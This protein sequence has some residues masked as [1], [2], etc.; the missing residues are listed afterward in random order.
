MR[1]LLDEFEKTHPGIKVVYKMQSPQEYRER[2]QSALNNNN[3]PDVFRIHN[4]WLPMF[5]GALSPV[6]S[7]V[8]STVDY[9]KTFYPVTKTDFSSQGIYYAVP[10][11]TDGIA[12]YVNDDLLEQNN[13]SAPENWDQLKE[14]AITLAK[15]DS[16]TGSCEYG[17]KLT[18]AGVAIGSTKNVDHW[19]DIL[20]VLLLQNGVN[21]LTPA[22]PNTNAADDAISYFANFVNTYRVWDENFPNST[23][24]FASGKVGVYF[25][26][27]WRVFD[28]KS[29]NPKLRF[30]VH[31]IPQVAIEPGRGEQQI[32]YASYWAEAVSA[33]SKNQKQAWELVAF[34]SQPDTLRKL[35][36][37]A[38]DDQRSFG[39][40][41]SRKDMASELQTAQYANVFV[42]Q[43]PLARSWYLASF[44]HDGKTGINTQLSELFAKVVARSVSVSSLANEINKILSTYGLAAAPIEKPQELAF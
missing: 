35:Y 3:G 42:K 34:M 39:E 29:L 18:T 21:M 40:P 16:L 43:A 26:P 32:T 17:A 15:C 41:Y 13:L 9:E 10:L 38:S 19:E 12:M 28:I 1:P 37:S 36:Q 7:T 6:P 11:E 44:T 8:F 33:K 25:G 23:T 22:I 31:P 2:V 5:K 20:A 4:T 14:V 30:S 24:S 27:S